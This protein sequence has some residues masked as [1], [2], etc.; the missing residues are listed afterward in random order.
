M[1]VL[2]KFS[3]S[4]HLRRQRSIQMRAPSADGTT[5][6]VI[7][8]EGE[9]PCTRNAKNRGGHKPRLCAA[10]QKEY[11][12]YTIAYKSSSEQAEAFCEDLQRLIDDLDWTRPLMIQVKVDE[13]FRAVHRCIAALDRKIREREA[14]NQR[15]S[16]H[17]DYRHERWRMRLL[18]KRERVKQIKGLLCCL[19]LMLLKDQRS[20]APA[21]MAPSPAPTSIWGRDDEGGDGNYCADNSYA[22]DYT[23]D[24]EGQYSKVLKFLDDAGYLKSLSN[25][26]AVEKALK[27]VYSCL[28]AID[29]VI[30]KREAHH[31][32]F[33][34][35]ADSSHRMCIDT[36]WKKRDEV[37]EIAKMLAA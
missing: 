31:S 27:A 10:R 4:S 26:A 24:A 37:E 32:R 11:I 15:F 35:K 22:D 20:R 3:P 5:C 8:V 1:S 14:H 29:D 34:G 36:L 30:E 6:Q 16:T 7:P 19:K 23:R 13:A 9:S 2:D 17:M 25:P 21:P 33:F 12:R 28:D 18:D